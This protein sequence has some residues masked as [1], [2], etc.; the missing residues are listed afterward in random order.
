MINVSRRANLAFLKWK[1]NQGH[2]CYPVLWDCNIKLGEGG[3]GRGEGG[4]GRGRG[5]GGGKTGKFATE[6]S[7]KSDYEFWSWTSV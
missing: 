6:N 4:G 1:Y 2:D 7:W 5:E 3:G